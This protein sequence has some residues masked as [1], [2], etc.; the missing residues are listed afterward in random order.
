VTVEVL[1]VS[2]AAEGD[3]IAHSAAM[4]HSV[5]DHGAGYRVQVHYLHGP[6]F[7]SHS[8]RLLRDMVERGGGSISFLEVPDR[9]V[10]GLPVLPQ[11][12]RAMWYRIFLPEL[13]PD[14]ERVLYLDADTIVV[15][16]LGPLW[17][18][19]L[20]DNYLGAVTNVFQAHHFHRPAQLGLAGVKVYFNS[21]VLLMNL[22][23]MRRD[24]CTE[25]LRTFALRHGP[26]EIEWPD[27]DTLNVVLSGRRLPLHPRWNCMNSVLT[28]PH[29]PAAFGSRAVAEARR[30]PAIRH[31][32]GPGRNKPWHRGCDQ[33]LR[34]LYFRHRRETPWPRV[35]LVGEE[36]RRPRWRRTGQLVS[37]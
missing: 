7:P 10:A 23:A 35:E 36:Q 34:D 25:A 15:D 27:Q 1:H 11:F 32:E 31:F 13:L 19:P 12:T 4:I 16:S 28:F 33:Q 17:E 22:S 29:S 3:Y 14:A 8:A 26:E 20:G 9:D 6:R 5:L 24:S 21:G 2:C 18:L 30:H 37:A